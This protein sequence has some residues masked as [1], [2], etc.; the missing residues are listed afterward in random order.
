MS[1]T[2]VELLRKENEVLKQHN[3]ELQERLLWEKG[4]ES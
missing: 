1:E 4:F 3:K 2:E